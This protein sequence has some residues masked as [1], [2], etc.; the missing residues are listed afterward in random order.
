MFD[1]MFRSV[2]A[3]EKGLNA[4][5]LRNQ[6]VSN[7]IANADTPGFKASSV[8]FEEYVQEALED[9]D[10]FALRKTRD[11]HMDI[12]TSGIEDV[13]PQVVT[14]TGTTMRMDGNNVD[15]EYEMNELA[16]NNIEYYA[17]LQKVNSEF[18]QLRTAITEGR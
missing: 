18:T 12:G 13:E 10:D 3:L 7:N 9:G 6:V 4:C 8:N 15:I 16:K 5:T 17:L 1:S 14:N 2:G 11:K